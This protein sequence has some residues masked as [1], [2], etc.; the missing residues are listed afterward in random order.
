VLSKNVLG[1]DALPLW[2]RR[3]LQSQLEKDI[4]STAAIIIQTV[5]GGGISIFGRLGSNLC[6]R[7]IGKTFY[8]N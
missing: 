7:A 3:V 8:L 5:G 4:E 2:E 6:L 1:L